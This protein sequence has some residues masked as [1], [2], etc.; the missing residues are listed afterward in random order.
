MLAQISDVDRIRVD[1]VYVSDHLGNWE[2]K[3]QKCRK[4]RGTRE[5]ADASVHVARKDPLVILTRPIHV[6]R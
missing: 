2:L 3:R 6:L 4:K 5:K 1:E